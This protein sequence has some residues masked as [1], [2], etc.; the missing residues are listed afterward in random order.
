MNIEIYGHVA[1]GFDQ[2]KDAFAA[3]WQGIEVGACLSVVHQGETI[4]DL[5]AGFQDQACT[6]SLGTR[7]F[8]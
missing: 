3:N 8:C 6:K 7:D 4:I 1:P 2:V 5:W